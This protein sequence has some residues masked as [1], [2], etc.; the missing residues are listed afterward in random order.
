MRYCPLLALLSFFAC[1]EP[2]P[3][4]DTTT[5]TPLSDDVGDTSSG[6]DTHPWMGIPHDHNASAGLTDLQE[7]TDTS[8]SA[9]P[10]FDDATCAGVDVPIVERITETTP[11]GP[12]WYPVSAAPYDDSRNCMLPG[13]EIAC[14]CGE[15]FTGDLQCAHHSRSGTSFLVGSGTWA[16]ILTELPDWRSCN[17]E[18]RRKTLEASQCTER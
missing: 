14:W 3:S 16:R 8:A 7:R 4:A 5:S 11:C 18:E 13:R 15:I 6:S 17:R 12:W 10:A 2:Q 1:A 9:P